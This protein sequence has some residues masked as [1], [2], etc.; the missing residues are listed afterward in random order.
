M[1]W[2][3]EIFARILSKVRFFLSLS[4]F[5]LFC[6]QISYSRSQYII[7]TEIFEKEI[8]EIIVQQMCAVHETGEITATQS[9][10]ATYGIHTPCA[11]SIAFE[12]PS[13]SSVEY[14]FGGAIWIGGIVNGDTLV[15]TGIN[16]WSAYGEEFTSLDYYNSIQENKFSTDLT[17]HSIFKDI[18]NIPDQISGEIHNPLGIEIAQRSH[19]IHSY[20]EN[21]TIVY[22]LIISNKSDNTINQGY[23][24]LYFD[25]DVGN[26]EQSY[27]S[28]DDLSGYL[29]GEHGVAYTIDND[30]DP[31]S[32]IYDDSS[33][34]RVFAL[35]FISSSIN[36]TD[37]S[38]NWWYPSTPIDFGPRHKN[39]NWDF[40]T[41]GD[42]EPVGDVNK[43][44]IMSNDEIDYDQIYTAAIVPDDTL[45]KYPH[46]VYSPDISDGN[47]TRFLFSLGSFDLLPGESINIQF[48]TFTGEYVHTNTANIDNLDQ[49]YDPVLF[50][51]GL[52]FSDLIA[53]AQISDSL[54][55][56][57]L[58]PYL[59]PLGLRLKE[60]I[61]N[62]VKIEW[63]QWCYNDVI[64]YDIFLTEVPQDSLPHP[65]VLPPWLNP[66]EFDY[67]SSIDDTTAYTF[68]NLN[69]NTFYY[70][71]I[72]H[73]TT[74][75]TGQMSNTIFFTPREHFIAPFLYSPNV[76]IPVENIAPL[77]WNDFSGEDIDH[78]N[79]Y[80]F[81]A[82]ESDNIYHPFYYTEDYSFI[83]NLVNSF[84]IDGT[85]YYY[86]AME[87]Y[88]QLD[89]GVTSYIDY[90]YAEGE[91]YVI[92]AVNKE[93][94][95]SYFTELINV[96]LVSEE[97]K[98]IL[99]VTNTNSAS[100]S[101][102]IHK[103]SINA[104]YDSLLTFFGSSYNYDI[105]SHKDS[106]FEGLLDFYMLSSYKM[107]IVDTDFREGFLTDNSSNPA[108][109]RTLM[110]EAYLH[111]GGTL[112]YFGTFDNLLSLPSDSGHTA[113]DHWFVNTY[114]GVDSIFYCGPLFYFNNPI[115]D[116][117]LFG[118]SYAEN[119]TT[120]FPDI[121]YDSTRIF[122]YDK[123]Y[124]MYGW[125]DSSTAI[126]VA[127]YVPQN[128]FNTEVIYNFRS[129]YPE[130]SM[131]EDQAVGIKTSL[132][133]TETYLF[134]FHLWDTE[135][136]NAR[137]L[138]DQ[139]FSS[140]SQTDCC[141]IPGD[142]NH[143]GTS[144]ISDL[145]YY[146]SYMFE[147]GFSP[148]CMEEFDND[149]DCILGISDLT[150][151]VDWLFNSGMPPVDCHICTK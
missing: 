116:D 136:E 61:G 7:Q 114:F 68:N 112:A 18:S 47:D 88:A 111:L 27:W 53:M 60:I 113:T 13:G 64:G 83:Y 10:R 143:D 96:Y 85:I 15:S 56:S 24:G 79:I 1:W 46:P 29:G 2:V 149:G 95:E 72:A 94:F 135:M 80:K 100:N 121:H 32:G 91:T 134:G 119:I 44:Y 92:S 125:P 82:I 70:S 73:N 9:N 129:L 40:G 71:N 38:F 93:G 103:D 17:Y 102:F 151:Y 98:D 19:A 131:M 4:I 89:S 142:A 133:F 147:S 84:D 48:A 43:Y 122:V 128:N 97:T 37:T 101:E 141:N 16:G 78:Y 26:H 3:M 139:M 33:A 50:W 144:G 107:V 42:G 106:S 6:N 22:D 118:F 124:Y 105:Y 109:Y 62:D 34:S 30:G 25:A 51:E 146:V 49:S 74:T 67:H 69:L 75:M 145:T 123:L 81:D 59:P 20:P 23:F 39:D 77:S 108:L 132:G 36:L 76:Y 86:Y 137:L 35:K 138:V 117:L 45:W 55:N 5:I 148:I 12:S 127:T 28:N 120:N 31:H 21:K 11:S 58:D 90:N 140:G 14:L 8:N 65:G 52:D 66:S 104:Y 115:S 126:S 110:F 41:G 130:T 87:L 150:Y 63:D 99:V 54:A 57:Y